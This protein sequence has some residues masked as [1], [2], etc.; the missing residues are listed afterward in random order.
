MDIYRYLNFFKQSKFA[1]NLPEGSIVN[2]LKLHY[3]F[4][5]NKIGQSGK[6]YPAVCSMLITKRCNIQCPFCIF[7]KFPSNWQEN[8]LTPS[9]FEKI[10]NLDLIKKTLIFV[11]SGGEPLLNKDLPKLVYMARKRKHLVGM[12]SNGILLNEEIAKSLAKFGGGGIVF[13][14]LAIFKCLYMKIQK[15]SCLIFCRKFHNICLSILPL[16]Y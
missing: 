10:L 15:I 8:E 1:F 13:Q 5:D 14:G 11:F 6:T 4:I 12:I 16:Y 3:G 7:G 2:Y 9:K